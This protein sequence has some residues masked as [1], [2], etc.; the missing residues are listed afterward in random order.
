MNKN[1]I[2]AMALEALAELAPEI[3]AAR[4]D[5]SPVLPTLAD[6]LADGSSLPRGAL[7]LGL[8]DDGLPVLL[9]LHDPVPGPLLVCADSGKTALLQIV[10][11]AIIEIHDPDDA[12]FGV[13]SERPEDWEGFD[14]SEHCAGIFSIENAAEFILSLGAWAH[15]N[16]SRQAVVL[17]M[18]GLASVDALDAEAKDALRWLLL[19]GPSRR[20]WPIVTLKPSDSRQLA[21]WLELFRTRIFGAI[22]N[23]WSVDALLGAAREEVEALIA[24][25]Q[26][27]LREGRG[28]LRFWIPRLNERDS[29][30]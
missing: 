7:F 22:Q 14:Q 9:N 1:N 30:T 20:V 13:I 12:Q 26:F 11:K 4:A 10:A 8:A 2:F 3:H 17:L 21:P 6:V 24:G 19:R 23:A 18:D 27:L 25:S 15:E 29:D 5:V 28:W 16:K